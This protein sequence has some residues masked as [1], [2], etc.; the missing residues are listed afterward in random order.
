M[1]AQPRQSTPLLALT[2]VASAITLGAL[3]G[4]SS[5]ARTVTPVDRTGLSSVAYAHSIANA[6]VATVGSA[7]KLLVDLSAGGEGADDDAELTESSAYD[8]LLARGSIRSAWG[9]STN[10]VLDAGTLAFMLRAEG[11]L[12]QSTNERLASFTGLGDRRYA[13]RSCIADGL[14]PPQRADAPV[15]GG[16]L[17]DA[18]ANLAERID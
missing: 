8:G 12:V 5:A 7:A 11:D 10:A 18:V 1:T 14:L 13:L 15:S 3:A 16:A 9:L 2:A 17:L 4:C 6:P